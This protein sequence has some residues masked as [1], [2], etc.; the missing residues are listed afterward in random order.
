VILG[1]VA[2]PNVVLF[3]VRVGKLTRVVSL[4]RFSRFGTEF[5][6]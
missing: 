5:T 2:H 4:G 6:V 1:G 3:D